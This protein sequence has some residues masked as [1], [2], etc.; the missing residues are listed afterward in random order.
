[1]P[2][3]FCERQNSNIPL[4]NLGFWQVLSDNFSSTLSIKEWTRAGGSNTVILMNRNTTAVILTFY[5]Y[6][7]IQSEDVDRAHSELTEKSLLVHKFI[8]H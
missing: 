5:M 8:G 4:I 6:I 2:S 7:S 1:M 3:L